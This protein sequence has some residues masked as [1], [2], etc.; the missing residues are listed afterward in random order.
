VFLYTI[1]GQ[2]SILYA[3]IIT[4]WLV[5]LPGFLIISGVS[6]INVMSLVVPVAACLF[7][8]V[9]GR[10][11]NSSVGSVNSKL[12]NVKSVSVGIHRMC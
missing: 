1:V 10:H 4:F 7:F 8:G 11:Y 9:C 6:E 12:Q 3:A 5:K 2:Q